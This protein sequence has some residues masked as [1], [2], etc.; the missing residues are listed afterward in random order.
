MMYLCIVSLGITN[1][2][3]MCLVYLFRIKII[4]MLGVYQNNMLTTIQP[5][6]KKKN[7]HNTIN[8]F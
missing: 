4:C 8:I 5:F 2:T 3:S 7:E 1:G 6:I